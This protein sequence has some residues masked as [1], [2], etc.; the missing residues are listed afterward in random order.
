MRHHSDQ[1][2]I[3]IRARCAENQARANFRSQAEGPQAKPR[4]GA[5]PSLLDLVP[6]VLLE[7]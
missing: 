6:I 5:V 2:S 1:R 4:L 3:F 7:N